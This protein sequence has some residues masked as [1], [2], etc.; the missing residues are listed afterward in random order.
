MKTL[1]EQINKLSTRYSKEENVL[2]ESDALLASWRW[3]SA[4][5]EEAYQ[6]QTC[7]MAQIEY[8]DSIVEYLDRLIREIENSKLWKLSETTVTLDE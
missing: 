5:R 8:R 2:S 3:L 7:D 4:K 6:L 1:E